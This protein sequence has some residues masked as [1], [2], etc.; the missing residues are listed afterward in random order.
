MS[1]K[2]HKNDAAKQKAYR[3]RERKKKRIEQLRHD[4]A[5]WNPE[6]GTVHYFDGRDKP[7]RMNDCP[8]C[9]P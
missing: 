6:G 8:L 5:R 2:I 4:H 7:V 3:D 9:T 1:L